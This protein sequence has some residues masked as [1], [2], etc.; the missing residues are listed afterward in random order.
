[1][2]KGID[3]SQRIE[4]VSKNDKEELKTIFIFKPLSAEEMLDFATDS[5]N[6]QLKLSGQKIF[7]FLGKSIVE[8]KNYETVTGSILDILKSMPPFIIA[9]LVQESANI[10]KMTGQDQKN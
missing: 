10:N 9:E 2:I 4:Y 7:D 5:E 1:M 3:V 6:G 8:I